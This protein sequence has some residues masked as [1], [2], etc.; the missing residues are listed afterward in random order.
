MAAER[1]AKSARF[2]LF[3]VDLVS[4]ELR[5]DGTRV[6][7]Q[8]QPFRVLA[9]LLECPGEMVTREEMRSQLWP[10]DTF[11]DFDHGLNTAVNKLREALGDA[12]ANPRFVQTVARRGYRFI[13]P[14]QQ[15]GVNATAAASIQGAP[16]GDEVDSDTGAGSLHPEL[17]VPVPR[18]G[19]TRGLFILIQ[20]MYLI[21][22]VAALFRW[23]EV[24]RI[25]DGFLPGWGASAIVIAVLVT[26]G[27][28]IPLR[29]YLISG[30]AFDHVRLGEKFHR[31]FPAILVLDELW[32]VAPFLLAEKIG[33]G[34]AFAATAGLLYLPFSERS[35]V[36]MAY[37]GRG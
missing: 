11:V 24:Q 19:V 36:R 3:E 34:A 26:A 31:L 20:I 4:G 22:Y 32:A 15:N 9:M 16:A 2:G 30:A 27:V 17:E 25:A 23:Q 21:F 35:L 13:A 29:F 28:G 33:F 6:R 8:E 14:V 18:R 5:K 12:A 7:L 10:G 1:S 37:P